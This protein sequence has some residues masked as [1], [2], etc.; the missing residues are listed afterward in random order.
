MKHR[1]HLVMA[2]VAVATLLAAG[3]AS[4]QGQTETGEPTRPFQG[5]FGGNE[6]DAR[7]RQTLNFTFSAFANYEN[8]D[9]TVP[10][11]DIIQQLSPIMTQTGLYFGGMSGLDYRRRWRRA[12]FSVAGGTAARYYPD[13]KEFTRIRDYGTVAFTYAFGPKTTLNASQAVW[14]SPVLHERLVP[15]HEPVRARPAY[16]AWF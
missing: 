15:Q 3:P 7:S 12:S 16:Y 13:F 1:P 9:I 6:A 10:N 11:P 8:N 5:L 2:L 14:Y 4:G